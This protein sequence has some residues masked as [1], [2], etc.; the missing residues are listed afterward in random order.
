M[1]RRFNV[2]NQEMFNQ[3]NYLPGMR[4]WVHNMDSDIRLECSIVIS[5]F[6]N[7]TSYVAVIS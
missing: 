4:K 1:I 3:T 7:V 5:Q 2:T 6:E